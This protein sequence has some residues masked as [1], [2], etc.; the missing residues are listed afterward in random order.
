MKLECKI[1]GKI[2]QNTSHLKRH[3]MTP[4]QYYDKYIR[5]SDEGYC[6][7]CNNETRFISLTNGYVTTCGYSCSSYFREKNRSKENIEKANEKRRNTCMKLY[8]S[9]HPMKN[10]TVKQKLADTNLKKYGVPNVWSRNSPIRDKIEEGFIEKYGGVGWGSKKN[11]NPD[12]HKKAGSSH[13]QNILNKEKELNCTSQSHLVDKYGQGFLYASILPEEAIVYEKQTG[14]K[15]VKNEFIPMIEE[16]ANR[17][18][19]G[20]TI[21]EKQIISDIKSIYNKKIISQYK[22]GRREIDI[23]LPDLNLGIEFNGNRWHSIEF[24]K[25][26]AH[27]L[28]KSLLC[29]EKGIRLIH[30]YEFENLDEQIKLLKDLILGIDNYPKNDFNKNNLIDNIPEPEIIYQEN[31]LCIYGAGRLY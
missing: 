23:Y 10:D 21:P 3:N 18:Q 27:H 24:K 31:R 30:I 2:F 14:S 5:K 1:C 8:D 13:R 25:D 16:Y 12:M 22:I 6:P 17:Y 4:K 9:S 19:D 29:R 20:K 15:F 28:K 26:P 7:I 11:F